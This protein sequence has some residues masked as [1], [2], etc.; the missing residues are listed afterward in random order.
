M[1]LVRCVYLAWGSGA[2]ELI[3]V[4]EV[5]AAD[6]KERSARV[7]ALIFGRMRPKADLTP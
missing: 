4:T 5:A 1:K 3:S 2:T 6:A 7:N